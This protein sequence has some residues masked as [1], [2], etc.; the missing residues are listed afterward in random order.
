MI[1]PVPNLTVSPIYPI[2]WLLIGVWLAFVHHHDPRPAG[3]TRP[4]RSIV[5][6]DW[7][8]MRARR[9]CWTMARRARTRSILRRR[10]TP[11]TLI[12]R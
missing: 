6:D 2:A 11:P 8:L 7:I 1:H 4:R 12:R 10:R 9:C 5:R 3:H